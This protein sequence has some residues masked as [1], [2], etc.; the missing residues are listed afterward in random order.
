MRGRRAAIAAGSVIALLVVAMLVARVEVASALAGADGLVSFTTPQGIEVVNLDAIGDGAHLLIPGGRD[1]A[2][3]PR[4][5][6][7]A[8]V[9]ASSVLWVARA[10]GSNPRR[11]SL[12]NEEGLRPAWSPDGRLAYSKGASIEIVDADG[13]HRK[14][15]DLRG[16]IASFAWTT[17]GHLVIVL[18]PPGMGP[19]PFIAKGDGSHLRAL[20]L[21]DGSVPDAV[22][23][24]YDWQFS[25]TGVVAYI[26][27]PL[28]DG[29]RVH[30]ESFDGTYLHEPPYNDPWLFRGRDNVALS[31]SGDRAVLTSGGLGVWDVDPTTLAITPEATWLP[32]SSAVSGIDWQP[33]CKINGTPGNDVLVGTSGV[34]VICGGG[35]NDT[36]RGFG[37]NDVIF[38]GLGNDT[39]YGG[40]GNDVLVGGIGQDTIHACIGND[41][42]NSRD[43]QIND[44]V[45]G[46]GHDTYITNRG[47]SITTCP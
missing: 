5:N 45:Q 43:N 27:A 3:S 13:S 23:D 9:D 47:D 37:G 25:S 31:P 41:L 10:D 20:T 34:D 1:A 39:I 15:L 16:G 6:L 8:Y 22:Y 46:Q 14:V 7:I 11:I 44:S 40:G 24:S 35:G 42:V 29:V 17:D 26:V 30:F 19:R 2:W 21:P 38:G 28:D 4:G 18:V 36:I 32:I 12:P 33:L